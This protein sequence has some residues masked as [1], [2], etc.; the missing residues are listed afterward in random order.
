[1]NRGI[2]I[3]RESARALGDRLSSELGAE[4][5]TAPRGE[6]RQAFRDVFASRSQWIIIGTSGV[7]TRFVSGLLE[8]KQSDPAVVMTGVAPVTRATS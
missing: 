7:A 5:E 6:N 1:M 8:S 2:W 4:I 3:L